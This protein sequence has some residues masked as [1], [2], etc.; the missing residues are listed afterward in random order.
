MLAAKK[1]NQIQY[2][3]KNEFNII[4]FGQQKVVAILILS[5]SKYV[6]I[7]NKSS[8]DTAIHLE[9]SQIATLYFTFKNIPTLLKI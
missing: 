5:T 6:N 7:C 9:G 4:T 1:W 8:W 2:P 3:S